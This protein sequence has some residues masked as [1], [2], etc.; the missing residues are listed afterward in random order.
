MNTL[1]I[2]RNTQNSGV[3]IEMRTFRKTQSIRRHGEDVHTASVP[4]PFAP[5]FGLSR[6]K[7]VVLSSVGKVFGWVPIE[8][9][10]PAVVV[11]FEGVG[12][13][14]LLDA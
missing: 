7:V 6:E 14:G 11:V 2:H 12:L 4:F 10:V 13:L 5:A 3:Y 9:R 8:R 1:E